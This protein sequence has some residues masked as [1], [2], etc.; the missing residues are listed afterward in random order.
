MNIGRIG[1]EMISDYRLRQ[2]VDNLVK[3]ALQYLDKNATEDDILNW[4]HNQSQTHITLIATYK[5]AT[6]LGFSEDDL[7]EHL[8]CRILQQIFNE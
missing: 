7:I 4:I 2:S 8:K 3:I 1:S 6:Y 5:I